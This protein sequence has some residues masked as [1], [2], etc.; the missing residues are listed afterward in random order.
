MAGPRDAKTALVRNS[1]LTVID[2]RGNIWMY[3]P[4]IVVDADGNDIVAPTDFG[5]VRVG[6]NA[7]M[8]IDSAGSV[9]TYDLNSE[10]WTEGPKVDEK[11]E[12]EAENTTNPWKRGHN[13]GTAPV[14]DEL[15]P[16][17]KKSKSKEPA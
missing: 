12:G 4:A 6:D 13:L 17:K 7:I 3:D 11:L 1:V 16:L 5:S 14:V 15:T 2:G 9:W 8:V 10:L